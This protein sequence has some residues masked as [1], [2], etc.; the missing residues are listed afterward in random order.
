MFLLFFIGKRTTSERGPKPK[1]NDS[2]ELTP[3][4]LSRLNFMLFFNR[5]AKTEL[6]IY[7]CAG[8]NEG[9]DGVY[10]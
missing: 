5:N 9:L 10:C 8:V 4:A 1:L 2:Q 3:Y 6:S 7:G